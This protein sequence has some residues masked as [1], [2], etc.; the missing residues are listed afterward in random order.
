MEELEF[1]LIQDW[2]EV[3]EPLKDLLELDLGQKTSQ[4]A[5]HNHDCL[6][7]LLLDYLDLYGLMGYD[8]LNTGE[9]LAEGG[10]ADF[11]KAVRTYP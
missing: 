6:Q 10:Q 4:R 9:K 5:S 8:Y 11:F 3:R 7:L 2:T 1:S